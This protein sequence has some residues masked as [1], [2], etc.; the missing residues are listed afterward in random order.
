MVADLAVNGSGH[1]RERLSVG[2]LWAGWVQSRAGTAAGGDGQERQRAGSV[3]DNTGHERERLW[4]VDMDGSGRRSHFSHGWGR[5][6]A[7]SA[8]G[9][10]AGWFGRRRPQR[11]SAKLISPQD[12]HSHPSGPFLEGLFGKRGLHLL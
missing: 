9:A 2:R 6:R 7:D 1:E 11:Q 8:T 10:A 5:P 12:T 3:V 4:T